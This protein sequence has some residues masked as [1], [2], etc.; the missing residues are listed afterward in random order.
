VD[1]VA[2]TLTPRTLLLFG[3][4]W[5]AVASWRGGGEAGGR[6]VL[7][8]A[9][10]ALL[11]RLGWSLLHL[12]AV[13]SHPLWLLDPTSGQSLLFVPL[14]PLLLARRPRRA[15]WDADFLAESWRAL[16][17]ALATARLGCVAAGCCGGV[18]FET[19]VLRAATPRH[20]VAVY[21][22]VAWV[23]LGAWL[24][25]RPAPV[26]VCAFPIVF[27]TIR[28][29][30]EPW[31]AGVTGLEPLVP[32]WSLAVAWI[33]L[34]LAIRARRSFTPLP[35]AGSPRSAGPSRPAAHPPPAPAAR[36]AASVHRR[37][38]G[39]RAR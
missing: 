5:A 17:W 27:G 13:V 26:V 12:G 23:A 10:G 2:A 33:G 24:V 30:L 29:V 38:R 39:P 28:L 1:E 31:R 11:A 22:I 18:P 35:R 15:R 3:A 32:A 4:F 21:E 8:L 36:A 37:R 25:R 9:A 34:G 16:P 20:P 19:A 14:G 6:F 7:A